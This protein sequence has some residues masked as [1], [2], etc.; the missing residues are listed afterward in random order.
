VT[1][2]HCIDLFDTSGSELFIMA[3]IFEHN[4]GRATFNFTGVSYDGS[5]RFD[6]SNR[7]LT[8]DYSTDSFVEVELEGQRL[9]LRDQS[10]FDGSDWAFM[11]TR[12]THGLKFDK[13][14]ST[15]LRNGSDL[16]ILGYTYG[17]DMRSSGN[18]EPYFSTAR[19][20]LSG[21]EDGIVQATETGTDK[22][23]SGGPVFTLVDGDPRVIGIVCGGYRNI[24]M[25]TPMANLR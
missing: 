22:G 23:N 1:A 14:L 4:G 19:V 16:F 20:T 25:V 8:S 17:M 7:D 21:I 12:Y 24:F 15:S 2:R 3:N 18:L 6:F 11:Q 9:V 10:F 13:P 5:V